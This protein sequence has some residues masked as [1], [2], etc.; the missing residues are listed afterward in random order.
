MAALFSYPYQLSP[1]NYNRLPLPLSIE[2]IRS[3][4]SMHPRTCSW[5]TSEGRRFCEARLQESGFLSRTPCPEATFHGMNTAKPDISLSQSDR[6]LPYQAG[7]SIHC[8]LP[9]P[10]QEGFESE[11]NDSRNIMGRVEPRLNRI[12]IMST[13]SSANL[14][15]WEKAFE[16]DSN[17]ARTAV[18][19]RFFGRARFHRASA[20]SATRVAEASD[21]N[22]RSRYDRRPQVFFA[23]HKV[24]VLVFRGCTPERT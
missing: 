8:Y 24:P 21:K 15:R 20:T 3:L 11:L 5:G 12:P 7:R 4:R 14:L 13:L 9:Q 16:L 23:K 17:P 1:K 22:R 19:L 18:T 10:P 6:F 2:S